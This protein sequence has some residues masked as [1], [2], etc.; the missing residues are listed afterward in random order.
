MPL[1]RFAL[2]FA[3]ILA[4]SSAASAY[5]EDRVPAPARAA[6]P[7]DALTAVEITTATKVLRS[8]GK[9]PDKALVVSMS[10]EEPAKA[11]V[12]NWTK[13]KPFARRGD[14]VR[15]QPIH[16]MRR[17]HRCGNAIFRLCR[18]SGQKR[19]DDGQ[20]KREAIQWHEVLL[21]CRAYSVRRIP[22]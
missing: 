21:R 2:P 1:N 16:R 13:G 3:V 20:R 14:L 7:M 9:L 19:E 11:E 18:R 5:A 12:R 8:A 10:L 6:H 22:S 15:R 17:A 4:L